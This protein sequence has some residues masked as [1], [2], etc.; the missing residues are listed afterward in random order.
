MFGPQF[1]ICKNSSSFHS[2]NRNGACVAVQG[3]AT[4]ILRCHRGK[5]SNSAQK[6]IFDLP[7]IGADFSSLGGVIWTI[8]FVVGMNENSRSSGNSS[9]HPWYLLDYFWLARRHHK[10]R[11]PLES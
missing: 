1:Y 6:S 2:L 7:T 11:Y 10:L 5:L 8:H 4:S 3:A 9:G